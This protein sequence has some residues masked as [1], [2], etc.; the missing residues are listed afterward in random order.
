MTEDM[1]PLMSFFHMG[2]YWP[3]IWPA[4]GVV[5]VLFIGLLVWTL[6]ALKRSRLELEA[7]EA[8]APRRRRRNTTSPAGGPDDAQP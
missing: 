7:L 4:Y 2:G 5:A 1:S 8:L 3:Y 6:V